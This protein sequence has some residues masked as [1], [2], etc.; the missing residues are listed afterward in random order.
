MI[1]KGI[2]QNLKNSYATVKFYKDSACASCSACT[3]ENRYGQTISINLKENINF[4]IGDEIT[5]EID[6]MVLLKLSFIVYIFP[7]IAMILG[8]LI[9][10]FS[11][12]SQGIC[13]TGSFLS[14]IVSFIIL[15]FYDKKR[16]KDIGE[17]FKIIADM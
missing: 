4:K 1:A 14:L 6:D 2:I 7:T 12:F 8:Y 3:G 10:E 15:Y 9:L 16:V 11:R 5:I 17:D 13:I